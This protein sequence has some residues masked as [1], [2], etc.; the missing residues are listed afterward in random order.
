VQKQAL[1][2][3]RDTPLAWRQVAPLINVGSDFIDENIGRNLVLKS[4]GAL[5]GSTPPRRRHRDDMPASSPPGQLLACRLA[6]TLQLV[7]PFWLLEWRVDN[8]TIGK[9]QLDF[10]PKLQPTVYFSLHCQLLQLN[11]H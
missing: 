10:P 3:R 11:S 5:L 8:W 9:P 4:Q 7:M 6:V 2:L 1:R